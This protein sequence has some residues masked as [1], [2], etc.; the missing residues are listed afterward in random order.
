MW[1]GRFKQDTDELVLNYTASIDV[2]RVFAEFDIHGSIA[3]A[4]M[5]IKQGILNF[6][7]GEKKLYKVFLKSKKRLSRGN[8]HGA[9]S[10]RMCI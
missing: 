1:K 8:S 6:E 3:H 5:L 2:D 4:R 10:L 7:E 9:R